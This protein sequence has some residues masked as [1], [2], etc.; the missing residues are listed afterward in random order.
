MEWLKQEQ[1]QKLM[2]SHTNVR[3]WTGRIYANRNTPA[4]PWMGTDPWFW[5]HGKNREDGFWGIRFLYRRGLSI[6][7]N[8]VDFRNPEITISGITINNEKIALIVAYFYCSEAPEA[9]AK[10]SKIR[11]SIE[12]ATQSLQSKNRNILIAGDFNAHVVS[13]EIHQTLI[14]VSRPNFSIHSTI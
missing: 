5:W 6:S 7:Q 10:N 14:R 9:K 11:S 8:L 1:S 4:K 12:H 13:Q 3:S 2:K